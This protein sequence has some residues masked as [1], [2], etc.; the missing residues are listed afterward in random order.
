MQA[1]AERRRRTPWAFDARVGRF[2][3]RRLNLGEVGQA[4]M[5]SKVSTGCG[6]HSGL[7]LCA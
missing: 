7:T 1:L 3:A 5:M 6:R 2:N 4:G